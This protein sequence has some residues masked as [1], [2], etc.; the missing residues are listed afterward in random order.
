MLNSDMCYEEKWNNVGRAENE[1]TVFDSIIIIHS[2]DTGHL[3]RDPKRVKET[4]Q[5]LR[6]EHLQ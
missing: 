4:C 1:D 6:A 3:N 5:H 2:L